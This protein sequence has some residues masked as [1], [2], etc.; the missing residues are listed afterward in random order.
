MKKDFLLLFVC[1]VL[2]LAASIFLYLDY[3]SRIGKSKEEQIATISFKRK[4][5]QRKYFDQVIWEHLMKDSP[6]YN[7]DMIR[8]S[9]D[10]LSIVNFNNGAEIELDENTL[11]YLSVTKDG[12]II[13]FKD[14][15]M[16][17]KQSGE[18]NSLNIVS[19]NAVVKLKD[20]SAVISK[21]ADKNLEVN[22]TSGAAQIQQKNK[23]MELTGNQSAVIE[24]N[25]IQ[26]KNYSIILKSPKSGKYFLTFDNNVNLNFDWHSVSGKKFHLR[27]S[28][29]KFF[30]GNVISKVITGNSFSMPFQEGDYYW[31]VKALDSEEIS[32]TSKFSVL[33]DE[34]SVLTSPSNK[35]TLFYYKKLPII[36]FSWT[37][38][39]LA[40][41]YLL[42]IFKDGET[43][44]VH[45]SLC[46]T[47]QIS[48]DNLQAGKYSWRLSNIYDFGDI[49]AKVHSLTYHFTVE[50]SDKI[51]PPVLTSPVSDEY[52]TNLYIKN[53]GVVFSWDNASDV[54]SCKFILSSNPDFN[55]NVIETDVNGGYYSLNKTLPPGEYFWK[56]TYKNPLTGT[57]ESSSSKK[58]IITD[59]SDIVP[60][61]DSSKTAAKNEKIYLKWNDPNKFK[62]YQVT[63]AKDKNLT[64]IITKTDTNS[65][66]AQIVLEDEGDFFWKVVAVDNKK[67]AA[68]SA[69][70]SIT[71]NSTK[72]KPEIVF[73]KNSEVINMTFSDSINFKWTVVN[74]AEKYEIKIFDESD[75]TTP[76]LTTTTSG[77][78]YVLKN[79]K[80]LTVGKF[81]WEV[82]PIMSV[83]VN[84]SAV[85][86]S[87]KNSF[88]IK[89]NKLNKPKLI[90]NEI[91]I[92]K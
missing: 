92:V 11:I 81:F 25:N 8:T 48:I 22:M 2:I 54:E 33:R 82:K 23:N 70:N 53:S 65:P 45:S 77:N 28:D 73:P 17:A 72:M 79:I 31:S 88:T 19:N 37:G 60:S 10:S 40:T 9:A 24:K 75:D 47:K 51:I 20:G 50:K 66:S 16:S 4:T 27:I 78:T 13:D 42:E 64:D 3:A 49:D 44:P 57:Q 91:Y 87:D 61:S 59:K 86:K 38:S 63:V 14:G 7:K 30:Q 58:I 12:T 52:L 90:T 76:I 36:P 56:L 18:N 46:K 34:P 43:V 80:I 85:S 32:A 74:S 35:K 6:L 15:S 29:N 84:S 89:L 71:V 5:A 62:K 41:S 55:K 1:S 83:E 39:D 21:D 26:V 69:V 67:V 68:Q